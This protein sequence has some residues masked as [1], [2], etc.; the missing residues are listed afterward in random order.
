VFNNKSEE[1]EEGGNS[2][3]ITETGDKGYKKKGK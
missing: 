1:A 3:I 2:E